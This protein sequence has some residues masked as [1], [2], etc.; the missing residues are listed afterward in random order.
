M[1]IVVAL[2]SLL[3]LPAAAQP[4]SGDK[5]PI[6]PESVKRGQELLVE[7]C[8]FCHGSN[9]RGGAG[10]S[11][12]TRSSIVQED[13]GG[14]QLGEF[15]KVGRPE[16]NMPPFELSD[17]QVKDLAAFL[18]DAISQAAN[19]AQY[20]ILDIV[21]GDPKKG[22]AYFA[23]HCGACHSASG[24][25]KG[26]GAKY[27]P[28]TL[29]GRMVMPR[30]G[31]G[32]PPWLQPTAI[33]ATLKLPSGELTAPLLRVTDFDVVVY[34]EKTQQPRSFLRHDGVPE[35]VLSDPLQPHID[36]WKRWTDDDMHDVTAYLVS[37]K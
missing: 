5:T 15:L 25:M 36:M 14:V 29:Q 30:G 12:L 8:G 2:V 17:G 32:G 7:R 9:A 10:G 31:R 27:D 22:E 20:K 21:V 3:A 6:D 4:R 18:H 26:I 19:R 23:A 37:L 16:R 11:D 33:K 35:V 1:R 24:D 34:D 13:E 28:A